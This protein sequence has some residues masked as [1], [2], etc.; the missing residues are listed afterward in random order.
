MG[1]KV[2]DELLNYFS[3][4]AR[5]D[6]GD[7]PRERYFS[8]FFSFVSPRLASILNLI[9]RISFLPRDSSRRMP[10]RTT[11]ARYSISFYIPFLS[12]YPWVTLKLV[13]YKRYESS[14]AFMFLRIKKTNSQ[15]LIVFNFAFLKFVS[16]STSGNIAVGFCNGRDS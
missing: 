7:P 5:T 16:A 13:N 6:L 11:I 4:A 2:G 9:P 14:F 1:R 10:T 8:L 3:Y 12:I 15:R